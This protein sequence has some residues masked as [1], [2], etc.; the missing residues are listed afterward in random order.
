M[1]LSAER[2]RQ[3]KRALFVSALLPLLINVWLAAQ[4]RLGAN[5]IESLTRS[6]GDWTLYFLALTLAITPLRRLSGQHWLQ[7]MRR[8]LGLFAFFYA[9]LHFT[10]FIWFDHFFDLGEIGRDVWKRPFI[11]VGFTALLLLIPLAVTSTNAMQRRLGRRWSQLHRLVYGVALL[12]LL[13]FWWMRAGKQ[14]FAEP[15]LVSAIIMILLAARAVGP[16]QRWIRARKGLSDSLD[17]ESR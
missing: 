16:T 14:N 11:T 10:T 5:P 8:M 12:A 15:I 2:V 9:C 1:S 17:A 6:S 7:A 4:D 3:L 13:H